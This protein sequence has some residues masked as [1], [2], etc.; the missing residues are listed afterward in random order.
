M[1]VLNHAHFQMGGAA[2]ALTTASPCAKP[3]LLDAGTGTVQKMGF[4]QGF[5]QTG[6][7]NCSVDNSP[8]D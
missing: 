4:A 7:S 3:T 2:A 1:A 5:S 8:T 6:L